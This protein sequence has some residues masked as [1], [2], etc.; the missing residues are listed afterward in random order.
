[1][2]QNKHIGIRIISLTVNVI[3]QDGDMFSADLNIMQCLSIDQH[4]ASLVVH[5]GEDG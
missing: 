5:T 2:F 3:Y 4:I 1:M